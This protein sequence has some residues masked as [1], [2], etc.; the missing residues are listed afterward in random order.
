MAREQ[1]CR[2]IAVSG[3]HNPRTLVLAFGEELEILAHRRL[4]RP[5]ARRAIWPPGKC[6]VCRLYSESHITQ[7][8]KP[9]CP[10]G[11]NGSVFPLPGS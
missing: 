3:F 2:H 8:N 4:A 5:F 7:M 1:L 11:E 10:G 6:R 9:A